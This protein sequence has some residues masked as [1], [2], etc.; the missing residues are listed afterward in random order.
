MGRKGGECVLSSY[1]GGIFHVSERVSNE[2]VIP[3]SALI[4][5]PRSNWRCDKETAQDAFFISFSIA[6]DN[7]DSHVVTTSLHFLYNN[8]SFDRTTQ[9]HRQLLG[10]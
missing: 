1:V 10:Y 7:S 2:C 6:Q 5:Q 8:Q 3:S 4:I 9:I